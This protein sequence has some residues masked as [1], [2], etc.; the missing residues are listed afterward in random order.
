MG[1]RE[2]KRTPPEFKARPVPVVRS[3]GEPIAQVCREAE[4]FR[5]QVARVD[6][7]GN[8]RTAQWA[9]G[10]VSRMVPVVPAGS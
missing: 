8:V 5:V 1:R 6:V 10:M 9:P 3:S 7:S 4:G 2:R